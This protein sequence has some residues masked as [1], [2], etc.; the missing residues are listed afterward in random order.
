MYNQAEIDRATEYV[1][2]IYEL[3]PDDFRGNPLASWADFAGGFDSPKLRIK[4]AIRAVL[5]RRWFAVNGPQD[6]DL[7]P[8]P[9]GWFER[10]SMYRCGATQILYWFARSLANLNYDTTQHPSF[11]DY[12]CGILAF[13][14][15]GSELLEQLKHRFPPR[16]LPGL[17]RT[18][19]D[20]S[21]PLTASEAAQEMGDP[22]DQ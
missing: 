2:R 5:A 19:G 22:V 10:Q 11:Y 8:L 20:W 4:P 14:R 17:D 18:T 7:Q 15:E 9:L 1:M 3:G 13:E 6:D 16:L 12:A 21:L